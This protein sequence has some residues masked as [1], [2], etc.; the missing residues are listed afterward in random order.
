MEVENP[1]L[2]CLSTHSRV[3]VYSGTSPKLRLLVAESG[4]VA[5]FNPTLFL[6]ACWSLWTLDPSDLNAS[7]GLSF[8]PLGFSLAVSGIAFSNLLIPG[9]E[10]IR[11]FVE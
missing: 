4:K 10:D 9:R 11:F 3:L 8:F 5:V 6:H 2:W 1:K 7:S